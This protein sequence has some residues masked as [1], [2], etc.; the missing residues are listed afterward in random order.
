MTCVARRTF[1]FAC[2]ST[3]SESNCINKIPEAVWDSDGRTFCFPDSKVQ[4]V[5]GDPLDSSSKGLLVTHPIH[6]G[7][8]VAVFG[9]TTAIG[10]DSPAGAAFNHIRDTLLRAST[11][12][13]QLQYSV[14]GRIEKDDGKCEQ[15][16]IIPRADADLT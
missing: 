1:G 5:R 2:D 13:R 10:Y 15:V 12:Q 9:N 11:P 6:D 14:L 7:E 3:C 16:W 4:V 8:I